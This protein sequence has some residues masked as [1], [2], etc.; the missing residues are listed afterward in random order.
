M[1]SFWSSNDWNILRLL[2]NAGKLSV[3]QVR[4]TYVTKSF[5]K[6]NEKQKPLK[7][8]FFF[9]C[10]KSKTFL[11]LFGRY[12]KSKKSV[13]T[14]PELEDWTGPSWSSGDLLCWADLPWVILRGETHLTTSWPRADKMMDKT[15]GRAKKGVWREAQMGWW[16]WRE[17]WTRGAGLTLESPQ[18]KM[19]R[20]RKIW[21]DKIFL[22]SYSPLIL[23][24]VETKEGGGRIFTIFPPWMESPNTAFQPP[25]LDK[26]MAESFG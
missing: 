22:F 14:R 4:I 5:I 17:G 10:T 18:D 3:A 12:L 15:R 6:D 11:F 26:E 1:W 23:R 21:C 25:D 8:F 13:A 2:R 7:T 19:S 9:K 16:W 24:Q 20:W